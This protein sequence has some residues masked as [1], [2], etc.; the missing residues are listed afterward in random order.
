M[1]TFI[2]EAYGGHHAADGPVRHFTVQADTR[3]AAIAMV[4]QSWSTQVYGRFDAVEE[5]E[6]P[7][8]RRRVSSMRD[9]G[10]IA[11]KNGHKPSPVVS[12][13]DASIF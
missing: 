2:I 9:P 4:K 10:R 11:E 6:D 8:R 12:S 1:K 7:A 5:I 13:A 3:E